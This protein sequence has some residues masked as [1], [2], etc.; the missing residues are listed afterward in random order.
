[1]ATKAVT[2]GDIRCAI[3]DL[4]DDDFVLI[5]DDNQD[6]R[7]LCSAIGATDGRYGNIL[8]LKM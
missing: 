8:L 7:E 5:A 1:M 4:T 2:V 3:Q 6:D